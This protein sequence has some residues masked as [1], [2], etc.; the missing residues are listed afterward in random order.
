[1]EAFKRA[2]QS[3]RQSIT[4]LLVQLRSDNPEAIP[5]PPQLRV[6]TRERGA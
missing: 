1:M 5:Q 3:D 4:D 2:G 6:C